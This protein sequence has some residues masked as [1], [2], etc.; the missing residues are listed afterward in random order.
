M[1][2]NLKAHVKVVATSVATAEAEEIAVVIATSPKR[3]NTSKSSPGS[4]GGGLEGSP[5]VGKE[6]ILATKAFARENRSRSW[7]EVLFTLV[8]FS[9][10]LLGTLAPW[11]WPLRLVCSIL[12]GL[13]MVRTFVI[14]HDHQ[15]H[16]ILDNSFIADFLMRFIGIFTLTPSSI[17]KSSHNYHHNHNS[18]LNGARIGS[19]PIMTRQHY[20]KASF[21]DRF[22]YR[23]MRHPLTMLTGYITVFF[24]GMSVTSFFED[25]RKHLDGALA[26]MLHLALAATLYIFGGF[27]ALFFTLLLPYSLA[28]AL[29]TYL[30]YVQHNFPGVVFRDSKGWTYEGAALDSSSFLRMPKIMHW[31][32]ANIGYHHIHHLN[33][34]IPFYRLPETMRAIPELQS[35][36]SSSLHPY[37]VWCCLRL[38]VWDVEDQR[39][40]PI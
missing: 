10:A 22:K 38:S 16:A 23:F 9:V 26:V 28:M 7:W 8:L 35:P 17:W 5:R 37:D 19:F 18:K 25:P 3:K 24:I 1:S 39:M 11:A 15:H 34:R 21:F 20:A 36:K 30:F 2:V 29:G 32:T 12:G 6:L 33:A 14:F 31:F 40:I 27:S 13:L 4:P